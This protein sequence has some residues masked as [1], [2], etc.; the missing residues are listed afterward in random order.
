MMDT[1]E[2]LRTARESLEGHWYQ[3]HYG[4]GEG[5]RCAVGHIM[6]AAGI[7]ID[8]YLSSRVGGPI[9]TRD[10]HAA[11]MLLGSVIKEQYPG[12]DDNVPLWNDAD[13]RTEDEVIAMF[14]KAAAKAEEEV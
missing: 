3:G 10:V 8:G 9:W 7:D 4:D 1:A 14:E 5:D 11:V 6:S 13:G 12:H 2:I